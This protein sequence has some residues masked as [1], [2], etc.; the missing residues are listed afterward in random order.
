M[1][2]DC[3]VGYDSKQAFR[4]KNDDSLFVDTSNG[5]FVI[6][7][8]L[9]GLPRG[10]EASQMAAN[11]VGEQL[12]NYIID[13]PAKLDY[14]T[15]YPR[16]LSVMEMIVQ[17]ANTEIYDALGRSQPEDKRPGTTLTAAVVQQDKKGNRF[18]FYTHVGDSRIYLV[19]YPTFAHAAYGLDGESS[20]TNIDQITNDDYPD[21]QLIAQIRQHKPSAKM[22][23]ILMQALG[24]PSITV[25]KGV[26]A[27]EPTVDGILL[28]TDGLTSVLSDA[29]IALGFGEKRWRIDS[30]IF[31]EYMF[32][33]Q[34]IVDRL[35]EAAIMPGKYGIGKTE[36]QD[37]AAEHGFNSL[38]AS[39]AIGGNDNVSVIYARIPPPPLAHLR[40][41]VFS[42][43]ANGRNDNAGNDRNE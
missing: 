21:E 17:E 42:H 12:R 18:M 29:S 5:I 15:K 6:A 13:L 33:P 41:F 26:I 9:G 43:Q 36:V 32:T 39:I 4:P 38:E 20:W 27:L 3:L 24:L 11:F 34:N 35:C 22:T 37:Y 23:N 31:V 40:E 1:N 14:K 16:V 10:D 28:C 8:G 19:S 2:L 30:T 7:D 25:Q